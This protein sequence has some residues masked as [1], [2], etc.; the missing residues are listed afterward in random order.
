MQRTRVTGF[1]AEQQACQ[2]SHQL[3]QG[4]SL[5]HLPGFPYQPGPQELA[6]PLLLAALERFLLTVAGAQHLGQSGQ[7]L[8][9]GE[10]VCKCPHYGSP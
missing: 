4:N 7:H 8:E 10:M 5:R 3:D 1:R 2:I 6:F 9:K